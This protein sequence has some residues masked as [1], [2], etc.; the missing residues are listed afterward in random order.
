MIVRP[1][2]YYGSLAFSS[3]DTPDH[4]MNRLRLVNEMLDHA[5]LGQV[6]TILAGTRNSLDGID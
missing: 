4:T 1:R 2:Y 5:N 6:K 3:P